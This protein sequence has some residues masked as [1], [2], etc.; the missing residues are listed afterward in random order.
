MVYLFVNHSKG[1]SIS[2]KY[3]KTNRANNKLRWAVTSS[4]YFRE[5]SRVSQLQQMAQCAYRVWC[6]PESSSGT[7]DLKC[8]S[9]ASLMVQWLRICLPVWGHG[10]YP[11]SRRFH[12]PRGNQAGEPQLLGPHTQQERPA[13]WEAWELQ[14]E[15]CP[16]HHSQ[17]KPAQRGRL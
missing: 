7:K 16:H 14:L 11:G 9:W 8:E 4:R 5:V 3:A 1:N 2:N 12:M 13:P 10:F 17:R 15:D 6:R